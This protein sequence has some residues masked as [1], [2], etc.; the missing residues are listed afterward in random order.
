[1]SKYGVSAAS[2]HY[3]I[4]ICFR[5]EFPSTAENCVEFLQKISKE[6]WFVIEAEKKM[7]RWDLEVILE[8]ELGFDQDIGGGGRFLEEGVVF[9]KQRC[10]KDETWTD[11][12][13]EWNRYQKIFLK[14]IYEFMNEDKVKR[15][16]CDAWSR[17]TS[18]NPSFLQTTS[19]ISWRI[20][21][22]QCMS[23]IF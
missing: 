2:R 6:K 13:C 18:D 12:L 23:N 19:L 8:E 16:V 10:D 17:H 14:G 3:L 5:P 4:N 1:M 15:T 9:K 21:M 22:Q 11:L 20:T 7:T